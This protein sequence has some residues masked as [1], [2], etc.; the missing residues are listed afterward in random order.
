MR[1]GA[2]I[3][4]VQI[5]C[6]DMRWELLGWG[7][8]VRWRCD[9]IGDYWGK[10]CLVSGKWEWWL[11]LSCATKLGCATTILFDILC[12]F[13]GVRGCM[14]NVASVVTYKACNSWAFS[15]ARRS[16]LRNY[17]I[18]LNFNWIVLIFLIKDSLNRISIFFQSR[19]LTSLISSRYVSI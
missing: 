4:A 16:I 15:R 11:D 6:T 10:G 9:G 18:R 5:R 2:W 12:Y 17:F 8:E 7:E 19:F 13:T 14:C 1:T 3:D